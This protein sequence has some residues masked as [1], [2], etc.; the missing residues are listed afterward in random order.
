MNRYPRPVLVLAVLAG[1][2]ALILYLGRNTEPPEAGVTP[3]PVAGRAD[4]PATA[5]L[6]DA[7]RRQP[8]PESCGWATRWW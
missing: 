6:P 4:L 8:P 5:P 1:L 3:P 7:G 2:I